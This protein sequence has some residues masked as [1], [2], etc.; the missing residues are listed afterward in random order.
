M[1]ATEH[2]PGQSLVQPLTDGR[3]DIVRV[4][5]APFPLLHL[6]AQVGACVEPEAVVGVVEVVQMVG[7][8]PQGIFEHTRLLAGLHTAEHNAFRLDSAYHLVGGGWGTAEKDGAG[9]TTACL[10]SA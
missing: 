1:N 6:T 10:D 8:P 4:L 7:E 3:D 9:G 5:E 2:A